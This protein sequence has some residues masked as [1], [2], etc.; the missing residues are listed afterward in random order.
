MLCEINTGYFLVF[1]LSK[2][3]DKIST[4]VKAL[5]HYLCERNI[6]KTEKFICISEKR[7][8][9]LIYVADFKIFFKI[10]IW[11]I[12]NIHIYILLEVIIELLLCCLAWSYEKLKLND[13]DIILFILLLDGIWYVIYTELLELSTSPIVVIYVVGTLITIIYIKKQQ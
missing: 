13:D 10:L 8:F 5:K 1:Y 6:I 9:F 11:L 4:I 2:K 7:H 12:K 3:Y